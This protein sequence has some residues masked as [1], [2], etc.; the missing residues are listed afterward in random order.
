[1]EDMIGQFLRSYM[2]AAKNKQAKFKMPAALDQIKGDV[3]QAYGFFQK[4]M[5]PPVVQSYFRIFEMTMGILASDRTTFPEF[6]NDLMAVY[7][8][9]P[10][11]YLRFIEESNLQVC[12]V[13][14]Q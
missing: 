8:D 9:T 10:V 11:W 12:R 5:D 7:W 14:D 3:R 13:I 1:M 6:L 4:F 2:A